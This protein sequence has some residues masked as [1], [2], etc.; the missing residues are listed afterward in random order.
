MI[1]GRRTSS[2]FVKKFSLI[3]IKY[4]SFRDSLEHNRFNNFFIH[5]YKGQKWGARECRL[6][7]I[8]VPCPK[9]KA[10]SN[11]ENFIFEKVFEDARKLLEIV[12]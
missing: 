9:R 10:A 3:R 1:V 4:G 5:W 12:D 8:N 7:I 6:T 2:F 11:R